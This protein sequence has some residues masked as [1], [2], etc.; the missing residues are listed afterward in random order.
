[1]KGNSELKQAE[2]I[3]DVVD[4]NGEPT[5]EKVTRSKAHEEGIRHRTSHVWIFRMNNGKIEVLLQKR[6]ADKD[7][8]PGCYDISSAGHIP[9]GSGYVASALRELKEELGIEAT[10]GE[11][12]DCGLKRHSFEKEFH[13]KV[14]RDNQVSRVFM[15]WRDLEP[16]EFVVQKEEISEVRWFGFSKCY[17]AVR[18]NAIPNCIDLS[19]LDMLKR[20]LDEFA[21]ISRLSMK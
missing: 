16:E 6:C 14:F 4:E 7:S 11:L 8:F 5:G 10:M 2:E 17:D 21:Y 3:F 20:K 18:E 13:G 9:S 12:T 19:E 15:L 1:M